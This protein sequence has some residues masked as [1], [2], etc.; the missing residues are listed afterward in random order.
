MIMIKT[1]A[2]EKLPDKYKRD[3]EKAVEILKSRGCTDVYL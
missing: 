3:I 1:E 2:F